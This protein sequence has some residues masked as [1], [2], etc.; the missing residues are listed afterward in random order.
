M[1]A[2]RTEASNVFSRY[3]R[4]PGSVKPICG[5]YLANVAMTMQKQSEENKE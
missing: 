1:Q 5:D 3:Y 4:L 2:Y